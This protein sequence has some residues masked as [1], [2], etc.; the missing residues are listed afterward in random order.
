VLIVLDEHALNDG[1]VLV[2]L[3]VL[4][5]F[6]VGRT[7]RADFFLIAHGL[8]LSIFRCAEYLPVH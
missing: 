2:N 8:N 6:V 3:L 7:Q 4:R 5:K 1:F